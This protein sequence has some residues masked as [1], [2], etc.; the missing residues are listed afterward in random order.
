M[1][2]FICSS[3]QGI[4]VK[5]R[6]RAEDYLYALKDKLAGYGF[7]INIAGCL[8]ADGEVH[9]EGSQ[10]V[11]NKM[12]KESDACVFVLT[13]SVGSATMEE[14]NVAVGALLETGHP[15]I[16]VLSYNF[17]DKKDSAKWR[18]RH[19]KGGIKYDDISKV[20]KKCDE[21]NSKGKIEKGALSF[22]GDLGD[23]NKHRIET[24]R[25][26]EAVIINHSDEGR[27]A[28]SRLHKESSAP[29]VL[30]GDDR[31][32]VRI[33]LSSAL[34]QSGRDI[35]SRNL[36]SRNELLT[37]YNI[38]VEVIHSAQN[39]N[40]EKEIAGSDICCFAFDGEESEQALKEWEIAYKQMKERASGDRPLHIYCF[41][42]QGVKAK[43][44]QKFKK[45]LEEV[46]LHYYKNYSDLEV[47]EN[48][49]LLKVLQISNSNCYMFTQSG[50]ITI[51]GKYY[52]GRRGVKILAPLEDKVQKITRATDG[53][54]SWEKLS[55]CFQKNDI[56][57]LQETGTTLIELE[58]YCAVQIHNPNATIRK[59]VETMRKL[60]SEGKIKEAVDAINLK[61]IRN[62]FN[63]LIEK[64]R[65]EVKKYY[66]DLIMMKIKLINIRSFDSKKERDDSIRE[67]Y[68]E[69]RAMCK[70]VNYG[71][72]YMASYAEWLLECGNEERAREVLLGASERDSAI[73]TYADYPESGEE[74]IK[75]N[76][77]VGKLLF[78]SGEKDA[79]KKYLVRALPRAQFLSFNEN[80]II[81]FR[82]NYSLNCKNDKEIQR[83]DRGVV[84]W[85]KNNAAEKEKSLNFLPD[86][87]YCNDS[88]QN[89]L[90]YKD[91][92]HMLYEVT[93]EPVCVVKEYAYTAEYYY[94]ANKYD[95]AAENYEGFLNFYRD[96]QE[97]L[98]KQKPP[99]INLIKGNNKL[100]VSVSAKDSYRDFILD[101]LT[102]LIYC[103]NY[104]GKRDEEEKIYAEIC[105]LLKSDKDD[106][107]NYY[108]KMI[109]LSE[110]RAAA[111][112]NSGRP[113]E[114]CMKEYNECLKYCD[115]YIAI[116][117][118]GCSLK[119]QILIGIGRMY[120]RYNDERALSYLKE[121]AELSTDNRF[122]KAEVFLHIG[123][124]LRD[125]GVKDGDKDAL[126]YLKEAYRLAKEVRRINMYD[127]SDE[128]GRYYSL[129]GDEQNTAEWM[130][131]A[132]EQL[133]EARESGS[134]DE[135]EVA[136]IYYNYYANC[137]DINGKEAR[138][139]ELLSKAYRIYCKLANIPEAGK[140]NGKAGKVNLNAL[141]NLVL[142]AMG[143]F[144][145]YKYGAADMAEKY[146][147]QARDLCL[148]YRSAGWAKGMLAQCYYRYGEY[149]RIK[150]ENTS[151]ER[152][153]EKMKESY[154][155]AFE[156]Y[157]HIKKY[158][159]MCR[160]MFVCAY[161]I[162]I[163][164]SSAAECEKYYNEAVE[165]YLQYAGI[166]GAGSEELL[167]N[168]KGKL[169]YM[170]KESG[171][172]KR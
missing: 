54:E 125:R 154:V 76:Y 73:F 15:K 149:Y 103:Y 118:S 88:E 105:E 110:S 3:T 81:N 16:R 6:T 113:T 119:A 165:I 108:R 120:D 131:Q 77:L 128:I 121:A 172:G 138:A 129:Q 79:A 148:K 53:A 97:E 18:T 67:N 107:A 34:N 114:E 122:R 168:V 94:H 60:L 44:V 52:S 20:K 9:E 106:I 32:K 147:S 12:I 69:L 99:R 111:M 63:N 25:I 75:I 62:T 117:K 45:D 26:L 66:F 38:G 30:D 23:E 133:E 24:K 58:K 64:Q 157:K 162:T 98:S 50:N 41:I 104:M 136:K 8:T 130:D 68:E 116:D 49:L 101:I 42:A 47:V 115:S 56:E 2:I 100:D 127:Y 39:L 35:L 40:T 14:F 70:D 59:Q 135:R 74:Y 146:L 51:D 36:R 11:L 126:W 170:K 159:V 37:G 80:E 143:M 57:S 95:R 152:Y 19:A 153:K 144:E 61:S 140:E 169:E 123:E 150:Q 21:I 83:L 132:V 167:E 48:T 112:V 78:S 86:F 7:P 145:A 134:V 90:R 72:E 93:G 33:Y 164:A 55:E 5:M 96:N 137:G 46:Y 102:N 109:D 163:T 155:K 166:L 142:A 151:D 22:V 28:M 71:A 87:I 85:K 91:V 43:K 161:Y 10:K 4:G 139:K 13:T 1:N 84:I 31:T 27:K 82:H 92:L 156:I 141:D 65:S 160:H 89:I 17:H 171:A 124:S 29:E 158:V